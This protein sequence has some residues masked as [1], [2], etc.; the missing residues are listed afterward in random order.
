MAITRVESIASLDARK[1]R[2]K[3]GDLEYS[4]WT[5]LLE[6][7][8]YNPETLQ[9]MLFWGDKPFPAHEST[10]LSVELVS[11]LVELGVIRAE[12]GPQ[13]NSAGDSSTPN[14]LDH[15]SVRTQSRTQ[16]WEEEKLVTTRSEDSGA[17]RS[18]VRDRYF[19]PNQGSD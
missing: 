3:I 9:L 5:L 15:E 4:R 11:A 6:T 2:I 8:G 13:R 18:Y 1:V 17:R 10:V 14:T 12:F 7:V 16:P 19:E